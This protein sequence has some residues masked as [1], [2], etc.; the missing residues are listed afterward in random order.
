MWSLLDKLQSSLHQKDSKFNTEI[1]MNSNFLRF[2]FLNC[3]KVGVLA[4]FK[5]ISNSRYLERNLL[6]ANSFTLW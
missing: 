5:K 2:G 3:V 4:I 6:K 1:D